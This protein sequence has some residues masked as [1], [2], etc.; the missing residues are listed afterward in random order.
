MSIVGSDA[1]SAL[2]EEPPRARAV[3][4]PSAVVRGLLL[5]SARQ[6]FAA[7]GYPG[8]STREIAAAAG[9]HEV[10]IFRHFENKA[11]L[12]RAAVVEPFR[13][14]FDE[15]VDAWERD[16]V[17]NSMGTEELCAAWVDALHAML[18]QHRDLV[19]ALIS[20]HAFDPAAAGGEPFTDAFV[21]PLKRLERFTRHE[22]AGRGLR[23]D[24]MLAVRAIFGMVMSMAVLDDWFFSGLAK[25]PTTATVT[26][27]LTGMLLYGVTGRSED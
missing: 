10:L 11:G 14:L 24:P 5:D 21:G 18:G 4:R 26:R 22:M 15:F 9:V 27:G 25:P 20:A 8:A 17:P 3:R 1:E 23:A 2:E 16:Y 19:L 13:D 12:F 7:K 6:L